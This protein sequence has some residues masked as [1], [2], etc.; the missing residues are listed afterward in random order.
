MHDSPRFSFWILL[1][2]QVNERQIRIGVR[3]KSLIWT[4]AIAPERQS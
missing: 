4:A 3:N 2:L 1:V